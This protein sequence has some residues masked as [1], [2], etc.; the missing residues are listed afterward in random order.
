MST[1][2]PAEAAEDKTAEE[3]LLHGRCHENRENEQHQERPH[4]VE[5]SFRQIGLGLHTEG[6]EDAKVTYITAR[7][8]ITRA[9]GSHQPARDGFVRPSERRVRPYFC[10]LNR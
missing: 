2:A 8:P 7:A 9:N 4:V 6:R 10:T 5:H 1:P 3:Y